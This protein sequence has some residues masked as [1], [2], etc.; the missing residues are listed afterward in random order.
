M[1]VMDSRRDFAWL[2][3]DAADFLTVLDRQG[4]NA[5]YLDRLCASIRRL[6]AKS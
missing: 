4:A 5:R 2:A 6:G 1:M 3:R